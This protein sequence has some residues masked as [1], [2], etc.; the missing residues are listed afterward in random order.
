[1]LKKKLNCYEFDILLKQKED[2]V[3][4]MIN[5]EHFF[6]I[7]EI[8]ILELDDKKIIDFA[9]SSYEKWE[10]NKVEKFKSHDFVSDGSTCKDDR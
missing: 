6:T 1:M 7:E 9:S 3:E 10:L 8:T 4:V 2:N 5:G